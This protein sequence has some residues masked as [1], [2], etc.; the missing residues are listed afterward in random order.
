MHLQL[1][2]VRVGLICGD[3]LGDHLLHP[4][5]DQGL[6]HPPYDVRGACLRKGLPPAH[7]G[8]NGD[9]LSSLL[10]SLQEER[11]GC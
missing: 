11:N 3:L 7:T 8:A 6:V 2:H 10:W 1:L 5:L 9:V 4:H